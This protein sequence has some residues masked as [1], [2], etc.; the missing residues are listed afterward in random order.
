MIMRPHRKRV[1]DWAGTIAAIIDKVRA[2]P[3][4][5]GQHDCVI[6]ASLIES[7]ISEKPA[8]VN[9]FRKRG[10]Y[11]DAETARQVFGFDDVWQLMDENLTSCHVNFV[12]SGDIVGLERPDGEKILGVSIGPQIAVVSEDGLAFTRIH[13]AKRAWVV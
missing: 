12:Q 4:K 9:V 2:Y 1:A 13:H 3:L 6:F 5:I 8:L 7:S 11:H 10:E